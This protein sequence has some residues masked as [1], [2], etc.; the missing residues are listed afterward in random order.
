[1][2]FEQFKN[3]SGNKYFVGDLHGNCDGLILALK[4]IGFRFDKDHLFSVGDVIDRGSQ[5]IRCLELIYESWFHTVKGNHEQMMCDAVLRNCMWSK[6][7]WFENGGQWYE[8]MTRAERAQI[9]QLIQMWDETIPYVIDI[10]N[11]I[12]VCHAE[13]F[14]RYEDLIY[15]SKQVD[16][17]LWGR[18]RIDSGDTSIVT[19]VDMVVVGHTPTALPK[20]LGN[21]IYLDDGAVFKCRKP[22]VVSEV[23]LY[24]WL[25]GGIQ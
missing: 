2:K 4:E 9:L 23:Q 18:K 8:R 3:L 17:L 7:V 16:R 20:V 6:S 5:S 10:D 14:G 21:T 11:R 25:E 19:G 13:Y 22:T 15:S 24:N 1:M 12:M